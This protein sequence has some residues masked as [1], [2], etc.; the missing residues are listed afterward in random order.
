MLRAFLRG[1]L[2][3]L[4]RERKRETNRQTDKQTDRQAGRQTDRQMGRRK[5]WD[6]NN[7]VTTRG[8]EETDSPGI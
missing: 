5:D 6:F 2:L 3:F 7:F 8:G 4:Q 1:K